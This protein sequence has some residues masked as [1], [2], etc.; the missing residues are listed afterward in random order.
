MFVKEYINLGSRSEESCVEEFK[1]KARKQSILR[2][3]LNV[4]NKKVI[5]ESRVP[6][7]QS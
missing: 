5:A 7:T 2:K 1:V 6:S 3:P 4:I